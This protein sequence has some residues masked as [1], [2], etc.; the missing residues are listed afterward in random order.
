MKYTQVLLEKVSETEKTGTVQTPTI[1]VAL[2]F[3][4]IE[5]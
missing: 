3:N 2:Q 4:Q 1:S 5:T